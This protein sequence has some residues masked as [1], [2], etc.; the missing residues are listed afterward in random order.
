MLAS[1]AK[2]RL[3][4][5]IKRA[6]GP[7]G[8]STPKGESVKG[9]Q[10]SIG[11]LFGESP[12]RLESP[13]E[14]VNPV[15]TPE[16]I[17]DV[18]AALIADPFMVRSDYTWHMF[19]EI[20]D[21]R[22]FRGKI[23]L[24][25]SVDGGKWTYRGIVLEEPFHLSYP[26]VFHWGNEYFMIPES[27]QADSVR[28][29]RAAEFPSQWEFVSTLISGRD[30]VD[31]SVFFFNDVWWLF[32]GHGDSPYRANHLQLFCSRELTGPWVEHPKSPIVDDNSKI[33][34]PAGRVLV[35]ESRVV[36]FAQDCSEDYGTHVRGFEITDLTAAS[37]GERELEE[38]P[39][40]ARSGAGWNAAGM[41]HID[42]HQ[43]E[44]GRWMACVDG[45]MFKG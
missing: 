34:R 8:N 16:D 39:I 45:W 18:Q 31:P 7:V 41:H 26:H 13:Q 20:L 25:T 2:G 29:Y 40:L 24:A 33:A 21:Q 32:V 9:Q 35:S 17:P 10:W 44:D 23:G 5:V 11:V 6:L 38:N 1:K 14:F 27:Y 19:F 28:L 12:F 30:Y 22:T 3:K 42:P 15:L 43:L 4:R 37:Y 36:R